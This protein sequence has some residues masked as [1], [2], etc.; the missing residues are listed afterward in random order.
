MEKNGTDPLIPDLSIND[1]Q[2]IATYD[3]HRLTQF[4]L[5]SEG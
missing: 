1:L 2:M 5:I 4:E 3:G